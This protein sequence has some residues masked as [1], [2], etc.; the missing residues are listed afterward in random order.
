MWDFRKISFLACIFCFKT[1]PLMHSQIRKFSG[2]D[3][4]RI[5]IIKLV[6]RSHRILCLSCGTKIDRMAIVDHIFKSV[7]LFI[8]III[9]LETRTYPIRPHK[10]SIKLLWKWTIISFILSLQCNQC[11]FLRDAKIRYPNWS[12]VFNAWCI[13]ENIFVPYLITVAKTRKFF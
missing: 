9:L 11:I 1:K 13:I 4:F 2:F 3:H 10:A 5:D 12:W 7:N 8:L 6:N